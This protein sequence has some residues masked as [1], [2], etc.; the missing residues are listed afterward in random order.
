[1]REREFPD[2]LQY[3]DTGQVFEQ[4]KMIVVAYAVLYP[5]IARDCSPLKSNS[6]KKSLKY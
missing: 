4:V 6:I 2:F 3:Q 5:S 1:M